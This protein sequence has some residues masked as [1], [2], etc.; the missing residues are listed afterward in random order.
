[1]DLLQGGAIGQECHRKGDPGKQE[2]GYPKQTMTYE[3]LENNM[4][5]LTPLE[6]SEDFRSHHLYQGH[7]C[8][9]Q[10]SKRS[11][12]FSRLLLS[13]TISCK[14]DVLLETYIALCMY[15][16]KLSMQSFISKTLIMKENL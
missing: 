3:E 2:V 16:Y 4:A 1:M 14:G 10:V 12:N 7:Y 6:V 15:Y 8:F 13:F 5:N 11:F 9:S